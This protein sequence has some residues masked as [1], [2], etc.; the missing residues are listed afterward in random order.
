MNVK[1]GKGKRE[2]RKGTAGSNWE[3]GERKGKG[4]GN[5]K[6]NGGGLLPSPG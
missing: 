2:K 1:K 5:R 3:K 6:Q 4:K